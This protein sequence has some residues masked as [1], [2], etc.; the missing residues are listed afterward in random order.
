MS[1]API[2]PETVA[3]L[4][5]AADPQPHRLPPAKYAALVR[6]VAAKVQ[7]RK[8]EGITQLDALAEQRASFQAF[9]STLT[10][11]SAFAEA[12][13]QALQQEINAQ[14]SQPEQHLPTTEVIRGVNGIVQN[15]RGDMLE[16]MRLMDT[17]EFLRDLAQELAQPTTAPTGLTEAKQ[18]ELTARL[19][20]ADFPQGAEPPIHVQATA[21]GHRIMHQALAKIFEPSGPLH[22]PLKDALTQH[23]QGASPAQIDEAAQAWL[24][25]RQVPAQGVTEAMAPEGHVYQEGMK[26]SET[27]LGKKHA[28]T[29]NTQVQQV[30]NARAIAQAEGLIR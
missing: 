30:A 8:A 2:A 17:P 5:Q 29:P 14:L 22:Q 9:A 10:Q 15:R 24:A 12:M 7:E 20:Q 4:P 21:L 1:V 13:A 19:V 27:L 23:W 16:A 25:A 6:S 18:Q 3:P 26:Q 11:D 28:A